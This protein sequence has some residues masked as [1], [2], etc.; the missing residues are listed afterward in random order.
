MTTH[1]IEYARACVSGTCNYTCISA[2]GYQNYSLRTMD[3]SVA[4]HDLQ[5]CCYTPGRRNDDYWSTICTDLIPI[6]PHPEMRW[7][8]SGFSGELNRYGVCAVTG[9]G[10]PLASNLISS[11]PD[12]VRGAH[13]LAFCLPRYVMHRW[14]MHSMV[15]IIWS[16][17]E[18][19]NSMN[20]VTW[21]TLPLRPYAFP[22]LPTLHSG[23]ELIEKE[24]NC[25]E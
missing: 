5:L 19:K 16:P 22:N 13:C 9:N 21:Y 17:T 11:S 18:K 3:K 14:C 12:V 15:A 7:K 6:W 10:Q 4:S 20:S 8:N 24:M 23:A 1:A 25:L 2:K